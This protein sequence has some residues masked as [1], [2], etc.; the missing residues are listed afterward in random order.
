MTTRQQ[1]AP[2]RREEREDAYWRNPLAHFSTCLAVGALVI[3][4]ILAIHWLT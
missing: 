1:Q 4:V 2:A 3:L